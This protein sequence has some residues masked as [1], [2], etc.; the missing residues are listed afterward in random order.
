MLAVLL[1]PSEG[2]AAG[3][4]GPAWSVADGRFGEALAD[5]RQEVVAALTKADGG[6]A[7][8]LGVTGQTLADS[9]AANRSLVGAPTLPACQ[10]YSG[11]VWSHLDV[12]TLRGPAARRASQSVFVLSA[13]TGVTALR[14]PLPDHRLKMAARLEPLGKLSRWWRDAVTETLNE[15]LAGRTV[16]DLLP[17][18]HRAAW[19]PDPSTYDLR[20]VRF[21][22]D[23]GRVVGHAAKAAKGLL[24][25]AILQADD[26]EC[27]LQSWDH[28][29]LRLEVERVT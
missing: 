16:I 6:D 22:N 20:R 21:V 15:A 26:V 12:G 29:E 27:A 9:Q 11:T 13:L 18:E 5:L 7:K 28:A 14:D 1:P 8:L 2:K 17:E 23:D 3:G 24:A 10:R 25:R 19:A 4:D